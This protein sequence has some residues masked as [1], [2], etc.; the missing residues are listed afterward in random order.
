MEVDK[1][2]SHEP[3]L[4]QMQN[5]IHYVI[6]SFLYKVLAIYVIQNDL[7]LNQPE[8]PI[9]TVLTIGVTFTSCLVKIVTSFIQT[10]Q[11]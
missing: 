10:W 2:Q 6:L 7:L 8:L 5:R 3:W 4:A 1:F 11:S 9:G